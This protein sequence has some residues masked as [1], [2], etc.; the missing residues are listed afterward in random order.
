MTNFKRRLVS[1]ALAVTMA[2]T[3]L[4]LPA[5]AADGTQDISIGWNAQ[6]PQ[7][8][9]EQVTVDLTASLSDASAIESADVYIELTDNEF[10]ALDQSSLDATSGVEL[11]D[12]L[13]PRRGI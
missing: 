8:K 7:T 9:M 10:A 11:V 4:P 2:V 12:K 13:L 5:N 6:E 1:T 3:L